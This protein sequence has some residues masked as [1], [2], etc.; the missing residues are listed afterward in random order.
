MSF[1]LL[2]WIWAFWWLYYLFSTGRTLSKLPYM[3][4][5]YLQLWFRFY[6]LQATLVTLYYLFQYFVT[7]YFIVHYV[8]TI[9]VESFADGINVSIIIIIILSLLLLL[10]R[11]Q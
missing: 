7:V 10:I 3:S 5:R 6:S 4:T 9:T 11:N 8:D 1:L 2:L